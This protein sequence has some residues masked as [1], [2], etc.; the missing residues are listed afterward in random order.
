[1]SRSMY[2]TVAAG[3]MATSI[4]GL[5]AQR[6]AEPPAAQGRGEA[7]V[8]RPPLFFREEWKQVPGGGEHP[9]T[10]DAVS[11]QNLELKLYGQDAKQIQLTG[12]AKDE[13]NPIH[14]WTGLCTMPCAA[15]LRDRNNFVDLSGLGRIRWVTKVSGLHQVRP[16][17]KLADGTWLVG[18]QADGS[19]RDW[20]VSE[21]LLAENRWLR[22]DIDK[23]VTKGNWIDK[24][25]L[26]RVDEVGFADLLPGSGHGPGGWSDVASIEVFGTPVKR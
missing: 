26:T 14:M 22:V 9:V 5:S 4:C 3:I 20:L 11:G 1:M 8:T 10:P 15:T 24:A 17:V 18:S 25:D 12:A 16:L 21:V 7:R 2:L 13:G 19:T 6:G 23:V